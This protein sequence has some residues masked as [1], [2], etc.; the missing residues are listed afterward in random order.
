MSRYNQTDN[1]D[2]EK[3]G[4]VP[5]RKEDISR[6]YI[7]ALKTIRGFHLPTN[8]EIIIARKIIEKEQPIRFD[9]LCRRLSPLF[10]AEGVRI[11]KE[12]RNRAK[13]LIGFIFPKV[14]CEND[15]VYFSN[16]SEIPVRYRTGDAYHERKTE[17]ICNE[18]MMQA[19]SNIGRKHD[20]ILKDDLI[21]IAVYAFGYTKKGAD[22]CARLEKA[23]SC[24]ISRCEVSCYDQKVHFIKCPSYKMGDFSSRHHG[25]INTPLNT[26]ELILRP[27]SYRANKE[28]G[29]VEIPRQE[30]YQAKMKKSVCK[31]WTEKYN[32][33]FQIDASLLYAKLAIIPTCPSKMR[34]G[35]VW[36]IKINCDTGELISINSMKKLAIARATLEIMQKTHKENQQHEENSASSPKKHKRRRKKRMTAVTTPIQTTMQKPEANTSAVLPFDVE[37]NILDTIIQTVNSTNCKKT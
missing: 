12:L 31:I 32:R 25:E 34:W 16:L 18:E 33:R 23:L 3:Y 4:F 35:N 15:F 21:T 14:K 26:N 20:C 36:I 30:L 2:G 22:I 28:W 11:T 6:S 9:T 5:Y 1:F 10:E 24:M 7:T 37:A 13:R 8:D 17:D 27:H 29:E 19:L